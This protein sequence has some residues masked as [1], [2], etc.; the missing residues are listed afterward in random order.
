MDGLLRQGESSASP[1]S[2]SQTQGARVTL[3]I[4]RLSLVGVQLS[5]SQSRQFG[6]AVERE[7]RQLATAHIWSNGASGGAVPE[8]RAPALHLTQHMPPAM[9]GRAVAQ[10]IFAAVR[11]GR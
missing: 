11:G 9:L 1:A 3:H 8:A 4:E 2:A 10:S 6:A 5:P 7:L